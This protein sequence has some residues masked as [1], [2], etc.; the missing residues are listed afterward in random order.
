MTPFFTCRAAGASTATAACSRWAPNTHKAGVSHGLSALPLGFPPADFTGATMNHTG[1]TNCYAAT[2]MNSTPRPPR[3]TWPAVAPPTAAGATPPQAGR[4]ALTHPAFVHQGVTAPSSGP[5]HRGFSG[6]FFSCNVS[7]DARDHSGAGATGAVVS[8]GLR[9][10]GDRPGR[11]VVFVAV[12]ARAETRAR[13]IY[14]TADE[15]YI[16]AGNAGRT[17]ARG[18][19]RPGTGGSALGRVEVIDVS[20]T[21]ARLRLVGS[22]FQR[23][24]AGDK[25]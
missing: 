13:V 2:T 14:A 5:N 16:D 20:R 9:R 15:V 21:S 23:A 6:Q 3:T 24:A 10:A 11:G 1:L 12:V 25:R 19:G 22:F 7:H 4:G 17:G 8:A 18:P